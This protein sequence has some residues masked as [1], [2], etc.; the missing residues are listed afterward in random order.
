MNNLRMIDLINNN[1]KNP[2][3]A[4]IANTIVGIAS[5]MN[6]TRVGKERALELS[7]ILRDSG[8]LILKLE[9]GIK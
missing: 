8:D 6:K 3:S 9:A 1:F 2:K 7:K 5:D 4:L